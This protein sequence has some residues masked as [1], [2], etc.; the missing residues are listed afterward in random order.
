MI[1]FRHIAAV[2]PLAAA[3]ILAACGGNPAAPQG[4]YGTIVGTVKS[5]S[6][7]PIA[8]ARATADGVLVSQPTGADGKYVIQTVPIDSSTT[9]TTV[10]C[11]ADG[12][13]DPPAQQVTVSAGK[14]NEVD[15]TLT[16]G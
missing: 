6:G 15:F 10:T 16:P 13:V 1:H 12:Y 4:N 7:Q 14:Q 8:G 2:A 9:S 5:S 11:H 3:L